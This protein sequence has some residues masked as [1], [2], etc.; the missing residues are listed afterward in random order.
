MTE[1]ERG[2]S[3]AFDFGGG[4]RRADD[5]AVLAA[6]VYLVQ[7]G[8]SWWKLPAQMFG[9]SRSTAH[10]RFT[11]WTAD[12]LWERLHQQFLHRLGVVSE[13]DW[14]PGGRG[15]DRSPHGERGDLIHALSSGCGHAHI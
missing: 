9:I 5:R 4:K 7:A 15:L 14:S 8:C 3:R 10:R 1:A 12:G 6:I 2:R 13:I 11:Q